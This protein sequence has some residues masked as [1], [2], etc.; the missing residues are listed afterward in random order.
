MFSRFFRFHPGQLSARFA[1]TVILFSSV[2]AL[3]ITAGELVYEYQRDLQRIDGR[4]VQIESAYLDSVAE[5]LWVVDR[6]RLDTLL[7]GISRQPDFVLAEIRVN[8]RTEMSRGEGLRGD[9]I[10]QTFVL[11]HLHQGREQVIGELVVA[12]TYDQAFRRIMQRALFLLV[13]NGIKTLL[14][15]VFIIALFYRRIGQHIEKM[16]SYAHAHSDPSEAPPLVLERVEPPRPDELSELV[17]AIN[18]LREQLLVYAGQE[19]MRA[20]RFEHEV[21]LRTAELQ[22]QHKALLIAREEAEWAS[23]AKSHFLA[24]MSHEL[25]TPLNAVLGFAQLLQMSAKTDEDK[26]S[27]QHILDGG[28]QLMAMVDNVLQLTA[29]E[30]RQQSSERELVEVVQLLQA[31]ADP[32]RRLVEKQGLQLRLMVADSLA[33][34]CHVLADRQRLQQVLLSYVSNAIK[35]GKPAGRITLG[36]ALHQG[37]VRLAVS[38][39]G[40]GIPRDQQDQ[41][42]TPFGRLGRENSAILGAGL[43]LSVAREVVELMGG[44]VGVDSEE[45]K[46]ATFWIEFALSPGG[47]RAAAASGP[48]LAGADRLPR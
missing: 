14:V 15:A 31:C 10:R 2:I 34:G 7:L 11:K 22:E 23:R 28:W 16:S 42:F 36:A 18:Q 17:A 37:R 24:S 29:N 20:S 44:K 19:S 41:L 30:V 38:D 32:C 46:G 39:E 25:R 40:E 8:G 45:G 1:A 26:A 47:A 43:G 6:D 35:Y 12:A 33:G 48:A 13:A 9:G 4:M 27:I 3:V 5:N 21:A